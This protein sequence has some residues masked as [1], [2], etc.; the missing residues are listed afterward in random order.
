LNL[1]PVVTIDG[2]S[3]P[4]S[5]GDLPIT[6]VVGST[7]PVDDGPWTVA[8]YW[9]DESDHAV[10][11]TS[12]GTLAVNHTYATAGVYKVCYLLSQTRMAK[13][14][15]VHDPDADFVTGDVYLTR[16]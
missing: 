15:V 7:D 13:D 8:V 4:L 6:I 16:H 12:G 1:V 2:P 3:C 14:N 5:S 9:C 10:F 11:E